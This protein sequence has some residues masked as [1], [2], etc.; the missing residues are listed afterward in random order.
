MRIVNS[1]GEIKDYYDIEEA[2]KIIQN[3]DEKYECYDIIYV[4]N[5]DIIAPLERGDSFRFLAPKEALSLF[6]FIG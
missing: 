4:A 5:W 3:M 1:E 2:N 6:D